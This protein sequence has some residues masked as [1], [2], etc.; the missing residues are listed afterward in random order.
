[1]PEVAPKL[2]V[3]EESSESPMWVGRE[4]VTALNK[5]IKLYHYTAGVTSR[6]WGGAE[7]PEADLVVCCDGESVCSGVNDQ[8]V[9][10]HFCGLE[11]SRS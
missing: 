9:D 2:Q 8:M 5:A 6:T 4:P 11:A 1:M 10:R 7:R 3:Q